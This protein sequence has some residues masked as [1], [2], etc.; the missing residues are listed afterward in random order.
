MKEWIKNDFEKEKKIAEQSSVIQ[1]AW[2]MYH[3]KEK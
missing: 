2:P 1:Y 3:M